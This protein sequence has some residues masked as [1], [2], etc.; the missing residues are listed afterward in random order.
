MNVIVT[1]KHC[2]SVFAN[3]ERF[4]AINSCDTKGTAGEMISEALFSTLF[5]TDGNSPVATSF[6]LIVF[7]FR[8]LGQINRQHGGTPLAF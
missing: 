5:L 3:R 7:S 8:F 1:F 6:P 2:V 4:G